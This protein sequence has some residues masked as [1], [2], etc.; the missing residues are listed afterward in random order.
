MTNHATKMAPE[1]GAASQ[2]VK[3]VLA[4]KPAESEIAAVAYELWLN[5]SCPIGSDQEHWFRAETKLRSA[6][7]TKGEDLSRRPSILHCGTRTESKMAADLT[8]EQGEGRWEVWEREWGFA[9]W[10]WDAR[11]SGAR[12]SNRAA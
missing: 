6:L 12:V 4:A 10:V 3:T 11:E 2:P 8:S 7:V 5:S 9:R 1:V